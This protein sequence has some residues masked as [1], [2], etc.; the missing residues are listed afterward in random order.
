MSNAEIKNIAPRAAK[1]ARRQAEVLENWR[2]SGAD[3]SNTE[4]LGALIQK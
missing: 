2:Q 3:I 4:E 1:A